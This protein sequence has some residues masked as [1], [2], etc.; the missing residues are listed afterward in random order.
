M[1]INSILTSLL[2]GV[3]LTACNPGKQT[4][5]TYDWG[6][7]PQQVDL[8]W[9]DS[10]GSRQHPDGRIISANSFGAVADS[11]RLSTEAIQKAID[12]C[13]AAGGGTVIL[14]PGHY[15]VGALFIKSGVNLQLDKGVTLLASTD[16]NNYP[17]FRSRIAGIEMIW[18]SAVLNVIKQKN[19]AISGE[20]MIDCRGKKFWDQYW[21]M[22]REY[23]KKGLRWAVDY[24][25]K[26]VRGILVERSTDVTLKDFTLMRTGFWACQI[27]YS[28][29]CSING[30]TINNNIGGRGPSTDG[31]DIDS[32]TNIL[33][34]NCMIDCNDDNICL[35]SG[36][37]TDGLRVNR[38][39]ENVVIRN[40]TTRKGAGLITCGSETSGGIRN[41]LGH[42][43]TA[44]GT[45]S[46]LRL[47]SAMNRGG[48]IENIYI[49]RVKADS[50]RNVLAADLNWNPQYSYS[51]LPEEYS[52]KEIPEHWKILLTPV[53]PEEKGYPKFRNV[54]LSHVKATNVREFIS[55]SGWNDT[56]RL[57]NFFL[58]AIEA[59]AQKAGRIRYSRNFNLAEIMLDTK[60]NTTIASE[61]NDQCNIH[62]KSMPSGNL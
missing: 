48:I 27:L 40:C 53:A 29:Y 10:V 42:D 55:A 12:E 24:D 59:Q 6:K 44:Q 43:L 32:S 30:L 14:A 1:R 5:H 51:T 57:E 61:N 8:S 45:W 26:R 17:E 18:P 13:S 31:V 22:R 34:E 37:D 41:I 38:P 11:T 4:H 16:I 19:V 54:Y 39:T 9:A 47:K 33:I 21:S 15:L 36:R 52:H 28:D 7:L 25:C 3:L 62:L 20:G 49:T 50:V 2:T 46:V 56:L 35:K 58:Y 60:D 23:E